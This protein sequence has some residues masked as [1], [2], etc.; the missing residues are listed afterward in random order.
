MRAVLCFLP[1][2]MGNMKKANAL[3]QTLPHEQECR[4]HILPL[5]T[6]RLEDREMNFHI[7]YLLTGE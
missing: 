6:Q 2:K 3:A 5:M 1:L 4:E 7:K